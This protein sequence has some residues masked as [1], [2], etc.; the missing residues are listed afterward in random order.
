MT[1]TLVGNAAQS[2]ASS[3]M[4]AWRVHEFGPP[5]VM[6]FETV[7]RPDPRPGEVLVKFT[8][9]GSVP[10]TAGSGPARAHCRSPFLLRSALICP[11]HGIEC[12]ILP[13][14]LHCAEQKNADG[15]IEQHLVFVLPDEFG[16]LA[17]DL[18]IGDFDAGKRSWPFS[19]LLSRYLRS[20]VLHRRESQVALASLRS[21]F[22]P[23][24]ALA[25]SHN[26]DHKS[27][28]GLYPV[29]LNGAS[30]FWRVPGFDCGH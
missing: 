3:S 18:A 6:I 7:P 15:V 20:A 29:R 12:Q 9:Q 25:P 28:I 26:P 24:N 23:N 22:L 10:G 4:K 11:E 13:D 17:G 2:P 21:L 14:A 19:E 5:E 16:R 30:F 1:S 8:Q 27:R